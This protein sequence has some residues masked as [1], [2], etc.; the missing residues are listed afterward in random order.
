MYIYIYICIHVSIYIYIYTCIYIY[1]CNIYIYINKS[2]AL[3]SSL[4]SLLCT[5]LFLLV[6]GCSHVSVKINLFS[7]R[8]SI[9]NHGG[10]E[11]VQLGACKDRQGL[12]SLRKLSGSLGSPRSC[13]PWFLQ[14]CMEITSVALFSGLFSAFLRFSPAF[15]RMFRYNICPCNT[16][17]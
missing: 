14:Y 5:W 16:V 1:I 11:Y 10:Q 6:S 13:P 17:Q 3:F 15:L 7:R 4:F 2:A 8:Y 9:R 12:P